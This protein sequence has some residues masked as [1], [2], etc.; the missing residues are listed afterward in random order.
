MEKP[1]FPVVWQRIAAHAGQTFWTSTTALPFTYAV[2]DD[3][4]RLAHATWFLARRE[5]E[6]AYRRLPL[7]DAVGDPPTD[8]AAPYASGILHDQRILA[9]LDR[10][11]PLEAFFWLVPK[12]VHTVTLGLAQIEM[13]LRLPLPEAALALPAWWTNT[14]E[15]PQ[16]NAWRR[17]GFD[18]D[19]NG[20]NL[21]EGWVQFRRALT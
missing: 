18:V 7:A 17:A 14:S 8:P 4:V 16:S 19:G 20:L 5:L 6:A 13:I 10:Y 1:A 11:Y 3:A 12:P 15:S 2:V 21:V 9:V